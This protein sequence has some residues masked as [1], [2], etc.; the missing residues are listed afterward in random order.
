MKKQTILSG[1]LALI[2][3]LPGCDPNK[4]ILDELDE[5]I[6]EE[7]AEFLKYHD[8]TP[9]VEEYTLT[10]EDYV[11]IGNMALAI[12]TNEADS[13]DAYDIKNYKNFSAYVSAKDYVPLLLDEE[14][15]SQTSGTEMMVY[16]NYYRGSSTNAKYVDDPEEYELTPEDYDSM[17]EGAGEPGEYDNFSSSVSPDAYL[18]GFLTTRYPDA[19]DK[20]NI[21]ILYKYYAGGVTTGYDFYY[22]LDGE[23]NKAPN[24]YE[25]TADD[26]DS[27]G[28]PGDYNNFSGSVP[29]NDYLPVLLMLKFPYAKADDA[30]VVVYKYFVGG[31]VTVTE[32]KEYLFDGTEWAEYKSV[33]VTSSIFKF[34]DEG[35]IFV[36]P[37][38]LI[39]TTEAHTIEYTLTDD[40]YE[41]IGEGRYDNFDIRPGKPHESEEARIASITIILKAR[42]NIAVGDVFKVNYKYYDGTNGTDSIVL[43]AVADE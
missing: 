5:I 7:N 36:P 19:A 33:I 13:S 34:T 10:D 32:A 26:Y 29:P 8:K 25:L 2:I 17:G 31:G 28:P 6:E 42:F 35:W 22:F 30:K 1:I 41:M 40:D 21:K 20:D 37:M 18:P 11:S 27:M 14:F 43:K 16:Y 12:A 39:K 24:S 23:W 38:K 3:L 4:D 9:S 15:Y